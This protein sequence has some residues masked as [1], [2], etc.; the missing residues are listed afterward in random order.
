M[1]TVKD[2]RG[3]VKREG[4]KGTLGPRHLNP[5]SCNRMASVNG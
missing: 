5:E 2:V 3:E 4:V 1:E